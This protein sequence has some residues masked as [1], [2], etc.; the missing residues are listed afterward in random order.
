MTADKRVIH[1][2]EFLD[3]IRPYKVADRPISVLQREDAELR[4]MLAGVLAVID[5]HQAA[6]L[7]PR[8]REVLAAALADAVTY[9]DP[10]GDCTG[11]EAHPAGLCDDHAADLDKTDA[12]LELAGQ[13]GIEVDR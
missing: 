11:C 7:T 2:R 1:A 3:A 6:A 9:R 4:R 5:E 8:Q 12:Y 13:L 10:S